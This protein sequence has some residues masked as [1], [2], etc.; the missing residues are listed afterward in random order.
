MNGSFFDH[1]PSRYFTGLLL[2]TATLGLWTAS[3]ASAEDT[4]DGVAAIELRRLLQPTPGE[5][6]QERKGR[7]YIYDGVR[8]VDIET[9]MDSEFDRIEH[10]MFIRVR[11]TDG[12]GEAIRDPNTGKFQVEDDGC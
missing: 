11:K 9:A 3:N 6:A 5:L 4:E 7:I 12:N 2:C 10:M 1:S 8:D